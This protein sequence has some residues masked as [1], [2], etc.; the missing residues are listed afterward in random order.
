MAINGRVLLQGGAELER[1][2]KLLPVKVA[3]KV[4]RK[5]LREAAKPIQKDAKA[6]APKLTGKG[7]KSIKVR[8]FKGRRKGSIGVTVQSSAGDFAGDEF[9]MS[10]Q[11]FGWKKVPT[12]RGANGRLYSKPRGSK[13]VTPIAGKRFMAKAFD[14]KKDDAVRTFATIAAAGIEQ[15][16]K[17]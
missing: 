5:A 4:V 7:A 15:A 2:L 16:A 17:G 9:Y 13:P 8:A 10:M 11:E 3:K 1:R 14:A 6:R 12:Y